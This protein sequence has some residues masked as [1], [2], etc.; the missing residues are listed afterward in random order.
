MGNLSM[1][2]AGL[3]ALLLAAA[4][5]P[6]AAA[7]PPE[8]IAVGVYFNE[9]KVYA[10]E[11]EQSFTDLKEQTG[12][13][14]EAYLNFQAWTE[15][16]RHFSAR[17][18]AN[19]RS[20]GGVFQVVWMPLAREGP[21]DP[22]WSCK[23]VASGRYDGYIAKYAADVKAFGQPVMIRFAHEMNGRWY[24]WGT[25]FTAPGVRHNGNT[26][27]DYV[28]LW[29]H[30]WGLFKSAGATNAWWVWSPNIFYV[31]A[32]NSL[33]Q[34]QADYAALYPGDECVDWVGIDGYNDGVKATWK[35]FPD[36]FDG[37]YAAIAKLTPKPLMIAE[38]GCSEK[39]APPGTS[40]AA[41]VTQT[42]RKDIPERYPRIRLVNWFSRD[43]TAQGETDWRFNSSPAALEAYRAAVNSPLY[44][45]KLKLE[46]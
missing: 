11:S 1:R 42:Y 25:A 45:G 31:N 34:Q 22:A 29:R 32:N 24:P 33:E 20:H 36:L 23:A 40:K 6:M 30:V 26:P 43:K 4:A 27:A 2:K 35:R 3:V 38:F 39:G 44:Q 19:A 28:A 8:P 7:E 16:W 17:L 14:A 15:E 18:A 10:P 46:R 21:A 9:G 37:P 5:W 41:W 13:L 12:R